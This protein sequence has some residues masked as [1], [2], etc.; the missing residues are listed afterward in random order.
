MIRRKRDLMNEPR[1]DLELT[2]AVPAQ[3]VGRRHIC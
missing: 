3:V 1:T 2:T